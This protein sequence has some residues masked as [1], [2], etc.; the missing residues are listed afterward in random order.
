MKWNEKTLIDL[1]KNICEKENKQITKKEWNN[2]SN[3]PSDMPIRIYFRTW[4]NFIIRC[5]FQPNKPYLSALAKENSR[6][7]HAGKQ[8]FHW[9]GGRV[10]DKF[11]YIQ[12]WNPDHPNAKGCGYIQEHRLVMSKHLGRPLKSNENVHHK[13]GK[14]D[15]NRVENLELWTVVQ[16]NG[17]RTEDLIKSYTEFLNSNGYDVIKQKTNKKDN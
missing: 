16:P 2:N 7:A 4:N 8:S 17:Q 1:Y 10:R 9:K 15:D 12:I 14:R 3:T 11:G 13:N 5:G 6:L